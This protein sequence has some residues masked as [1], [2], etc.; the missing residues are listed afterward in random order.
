MPQQIISL[1]ASNKTPK[2]GEQITVDI[3]HEVQRESD[4]SGASKLS[5]SLFFDDNKLS[6]DSI[7]YPSSDF[8]NSFPIPAVAD[9]N[10]DDD[11]EDTNKSLAILFGSASLRSPYPDERT[12]VASAKFTVLEG[13][14]G[15][16]IAVIIK[17]KF[18]ANG[19]GLIP[20]W[21]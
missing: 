12:K 19:Y 1:E 8:I 15:S 9:N 4:E 2:V 11:I 3:F 16:Q 21:I 18:S 7:D 13:F 6:L 10:N 14:D 17:T 5:L 20:N